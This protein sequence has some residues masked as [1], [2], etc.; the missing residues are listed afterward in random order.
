MR[1][2]IQTVRNFVRQHSPLFSEDG[3]SEVEITWLVVRLLD[4]EQLVSASTLPNIGS[5]MNHYYSVVAD[6]VLI[7]GGDINSF[8]GP[9]VIVHFG[10]IQMIDEALVVGTGNAVLR[11]LRESLEGLRI[12]LG[13]CKGLVIYGRFG[14]DKRATHTAFGHAQICAE[15]LASRG[16]E[17][18][19]CEL[20]AKRIPPHEFPTDARFSIC[21]HWQGAQTTGSK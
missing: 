9:T 1:S 5:I 6:T 19:V 18:S 20:V 13:V 8:C 3:P 17:L 7:A 12:G 14:S 4:F 16:P 15:R 11:N 21:S 2:R 10:A